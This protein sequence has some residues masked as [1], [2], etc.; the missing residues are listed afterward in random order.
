M[1]RASQTRPEPSTYPK[2]PSGVTANGSLG[3]ARPGARTRTEGF[4]RFG[5]AIRWCSSHQDELFTACSP[6]K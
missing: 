4:P 5:K 1:S 6:Q 3:H 2:A